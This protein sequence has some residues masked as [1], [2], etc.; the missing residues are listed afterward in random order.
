MARLGKILSWTVGM[1]GVVLL[2]GSKA[3]FVSWQERL[4]QAVIGAMIGFVLGW[5]FARRLPRRSR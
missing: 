3:T 2:I 5:I 1:A 4:E